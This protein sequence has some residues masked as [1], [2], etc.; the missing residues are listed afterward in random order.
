MS[1]GGERAKAKCPMIARLDAWQAL[2][3]NNM[4]L[5]GNTRRGTDATRLGRYFSPGEMIA[6]PKDMNVRE[7]ADR[8][9]AVL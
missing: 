4:Y 8:L 2:G 3:R 6:V 5:Y 7:F 1:S 9:V